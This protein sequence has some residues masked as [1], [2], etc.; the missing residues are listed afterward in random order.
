MRLPWNFLGVFALLANF[1]FSTP[2]QADL[3]GTPVRQG[4][5]LVVELSEKIALQRISQTEVATLL[6]STEQAA[7]LWAAIR[8]LQLQGGLPASSTDWAELRTIVSRQDM[9]LDDVI[10]KFRSA[11]QT[12]TAISR[13]TMAT[14]FAASAPAQSTVAAVTE[15]P[16]ET[17]QAYRPKTTATQKFKE[18]LLASGSRT[19]MMR[20]RLLGTLLQRAKRTPEVCS[21]KAKEYCANT[22]PEAVLL[23]GAEGLDQ[24]GQPAI[25]FAQDVLDA[26]PGDEDSFVGRGEITLQGFAAAIKMGKTRPTQLQSCLF[27]GSPSV[28]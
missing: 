10:G 26:F 20:I 25:Q 5:R 17:F 23:W 8:T 13:T 15:N 24:A 21:A 18:T 2:A 7:S 27:R 4:G 9:S 3:I 28:N 22:A 6:G 11:A 16:E 19:A 14:F 12:R 1:S